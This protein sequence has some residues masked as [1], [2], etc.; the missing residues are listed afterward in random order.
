M[1]KQ[2]EQ[3]RDYSKF[4]KIDD[5]DLDLWGRKEKCS[6][7]GYCLKVAATSTHICRWFGY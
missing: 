7:P 5:Y 2:E 3:L 6:D 4:M 1:G